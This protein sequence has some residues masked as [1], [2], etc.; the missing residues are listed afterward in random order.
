[1]HKIYHVELL[2]E[3]ENLFEKVMAIRAEIE[4]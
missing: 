4:E 2:V 3:A 1:L